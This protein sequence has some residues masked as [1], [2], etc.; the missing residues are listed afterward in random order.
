MYHIKNIRRH[1]VK[2]AA[3]AF[4]MGMSGLATP[5][6]KPVAAQTGVRSASRPSPAAIPVPVSTSSRSEDARYLDGAIATVNH[7]PI[8]R[9]E[10]ITTLVALDPRRLGGFALA[11]TPQPQNTISLS[12]AA[13]CRRTLAVNPTEYEHFVQDMM[14]MR[15]MQD[16]TVARHTPVTEAEMQAGIKTNL[17]AR[18]QNAE[19]PAQDQADLADRLGDTLLNVRRIVTFQLL[20]EHL[21]TADLHERLGHP[22]RP[23]DFFSAHYLFLLARR[24]GQPPTDADMDAAQTRAEQLRARILRKE[25][26]FEDAAAQ[27]SDD[28]TRASQGRLG[29]LPRTLL[30]REM[31]TALLASTPGDITPPIRINN[32]CAIARLDKRGQDLTLE[33]REQAIKLYKN[34]KKREEEVLAR[35][36]KNVQW[37]NTLGQPPRLNAS[38]ANRP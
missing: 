38:L 18:R 34:Y 9:R 29:A 22:L 28:V 12:L 33:E 20:R 11:Q 19:I 31:E 1:C 10:F 6:L 26:T 8:T 27:N 30:K 14:L 17:E 2:I 35:M 7:H 37:T 4:L 32:G 21:L 13:L 25:I 3:A 15:A 23:D 24:D 16:A 36:F 5:L